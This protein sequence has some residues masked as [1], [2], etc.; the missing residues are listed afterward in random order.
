MGPRGIAHLARGLRLTRAEGSSGG[1]KT[2]DAVAWQSML[3]PDLSAP[4]K[5]SQGALSASGQQKKRG[6]V[7]D[8]EARTSS[9][10]LAKCLQGDYINDNT[11]T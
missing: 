5:V 2:P 1:S 6:V 7:T 10:A 11:Y 3:L 4:S 8:S 9:Q